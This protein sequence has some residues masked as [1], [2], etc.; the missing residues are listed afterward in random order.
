MMDI[1]S[2]R[3]LRPPAG[4]AIFVSAQVNHDVSSENQTNPHEQSIF[5]H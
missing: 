4:V 1:F 3:I 2:S 5:R